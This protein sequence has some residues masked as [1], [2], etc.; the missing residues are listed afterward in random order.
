MTSPSDRHRGGASAPPSF[1]PPRGPSGVER[2][3][4]FQVRCGACEHQW[5]ALYTPLPLSK[6]AQVLG[7]LHCPRCGQDASKIFC[8]KAEAG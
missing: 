2:C 4:R 6:S 3:K 5:V 8:Q 1:Q 7:S